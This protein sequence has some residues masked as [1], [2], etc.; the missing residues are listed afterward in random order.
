MAWEAELIKHF[1]EVRHIGENERDFVVSQEF[2]PGKYSSTDISVLLAKEDTELRVKPCSIE[3]LRHIVNEE[4]ANGNV[5]NELFAGIKDGTSVAYIGKKAISGQTGTK[6]F[7]Q[8]FFQNNQPNGFDMGI[9]AGPG[10]PTRF[11]SEID[12]RLRLYFDELMK[13]RPDAAESI[14][15]CVAML[16]VPEHGYGSGRRQ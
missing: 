14:W 2:T 15:K 11:P 10:W 16:S 3:H 5:V 8:Y 13:F 9:M 1:L 12:P 7:R 6:F 4:Y